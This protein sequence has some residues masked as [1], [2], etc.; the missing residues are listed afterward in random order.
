MIVDD[1][2]DSLCEYCDPEDPVLV[3]CGGRMYEVASV[4][5]CNGKVVIDVF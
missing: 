1:L 5:V 3:N 4:R 2:I